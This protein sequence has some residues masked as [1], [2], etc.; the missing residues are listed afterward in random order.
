[1]RSQLIHLSLR[2]ITLG[3]S[4][5]D[6]ICQIEAGNLDAI[7]WKIPSVKSVFDSAKVA[8]QSSDPLIEPTECFSSPIFRTHSHGYNFFKF[9]P[10]GFGPTTG[11]CSS[12]LFTL[13]P[14]D[15]DQMLQWPFSK[16]IHIGNR[17]QLDP[18]NTWTKTIR[19]DQDPPY[20]KPRISK[21]NRSFDNHHQ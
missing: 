2:G 3:I 4:L 1:M 13:F 8:R 19:P 17:D 10:Y 12:I 18:L 6:K 20:T 5:Y 7:I 14:G 11:K 16:L 21:K 15:Y 9:Y